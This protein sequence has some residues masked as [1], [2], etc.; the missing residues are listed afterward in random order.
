[1]V[2]RLR[3][4]PPALHDRPR[5]PERIERYHDRIERMHESTDLLRI[6]GWPREAAIIHLEMLQIVGVPRVDVIDCCAAGIGG[7]AGSAVSRV[8]IQHGVEEG[9]AHFAA[10]SA[11]SM[12]SHAGCLALTTKVLARPVRHLIARGELPNS[13]ENIEEYRDA[14][15]AI[16]TYIRPNA[17]IAAAGGAHVS[18]MLRVSSQATG[19]FQAHAPSPQIVHRAVPQVVQKISELATGEFTS[20]FSIAASQ[21]GNA[22]DACCRRIDLSLC[23]PAF[24]GC[25]SSMLGWTGMRLTQFALK[26]LYETITKPAGRLP[27]L[28][29][30]MGCDN[31]H[32]RAD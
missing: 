13:H 30:E 27:E 16:P 7:A 11:A 31:A 1:M 25:C 29:L 28:D 18:R 8:L 22:C 14:L 20:P 23:E 21:L 4:V 3:S 5:S 2:P 32:L 24:E 17:A 26:K 12:A 9:P 10:V 6:S 19:A 15:A